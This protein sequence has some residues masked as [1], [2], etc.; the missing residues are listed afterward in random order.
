MPTTPSPACGPQPAARPDRPWP[1][2]GRGPA[3]SADGLVK[4]PA[5]A[6]LPAKGKRT[7]ES[8]SYFGVLPG[9][10]WAGFFPNKALNNSTGIGNTIVVF[11][12]VPISAKVWR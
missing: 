11:F 4:A 3:P 8:S 7:T 2:G 6:T 5:Q 1:F 9:G 12:S 10:G